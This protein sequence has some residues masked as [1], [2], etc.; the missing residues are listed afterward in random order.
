M[1]MSTAPPS[2]IAATCSPASRA[3]SLSTLSLISSSA[4]CCSG[5]CFLFLLSVSFLFLSSLFSSVVFLFF[6]VCFLS[7]RSCFTLL[8]KAAVCVVISCTD[9]LCA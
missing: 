3:M 4:F 5:G 9:C 1:L 6:L 8:V 2:R 7:S